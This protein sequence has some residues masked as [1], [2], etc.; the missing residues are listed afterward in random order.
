[1]EEFGASGSGHSDTRGLGLAGVEWMRCCAPRDP[2]KNDPDRTL[3]I[4]THHHN[5]IAYKC[6]VYVSI[7][8]KSVATQQAPW[9]SSSSFG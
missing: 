3:D 7:W 1:M 2:E 4:K 5:S 8:Q 9:K 6:I